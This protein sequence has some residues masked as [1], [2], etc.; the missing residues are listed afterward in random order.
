MNFR[1]V[2]IYIYKLYIHIECMYIYIYDIFICKYIY[3]HLCTHQK[4]SL[5]TGKTAKHPRKNMS[6]TPIISNL[7]KFFIPLKSGFSI[8][9]LN[10]GSL[11]AA[12]SSGSSSRRQ[13]FNMA[14]RDRGGT[15]THYVQSLD[16]YRSVCTQNHHQLNMCLHLWPFQVVLGFNHHH[17]HHPPPHQHHQQQQQ[18]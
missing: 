1:C 4:Y 18:P 16:L 5:I 14:W 6:S 13:I 12:F 7:G 15:V 17:H 11:A 8:L 9:V 2:C 10:G 3:T